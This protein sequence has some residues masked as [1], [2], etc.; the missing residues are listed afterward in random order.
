MNAIP[1]SSPDGRVYTYACGACHVPEGGVTW[2]THEPPD[3]KMLERFKSSAESCCRCAD[4]GA[5]IRRS[6]FGSRCDPCTEKRDARLET[7]RADAEE[8]RK[9]G[10]IVYEERLAKALDRDAAI[11]LV[12]LMREVSDDYYC[13]GWINGLESELWRMVNGGDRQYG[14]GEVSLETVNELLRL[15]EKAGGWWAWQDGIG[16][17]FVTAADWNG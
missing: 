15:S 4:C 9:K 6:I 17:L 8:D 13:A 14:A 3:E 7:L 10:E 16:E 2:F 12:D 1:L 5:D 11:R